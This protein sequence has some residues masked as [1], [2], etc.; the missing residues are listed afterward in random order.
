MYRVRGRNS[1]VGLDW[2]R[3]CRNSL[4]VLRSIRRK[5]AGNGGALDTPE[6][7][8]L[9]DLKTSYLHLALGDTDTAAEDLVS[10]W[11]TGRRLAAGPGSFPVFIVAGLLHDFE[12]PG[13]V[14][15]ACRLR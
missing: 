8:A 11:R 14:K 4:E 13:R 3:Q 9:I 1:S 5:G 2:A 10:A 15:P 7:L 12:S 6:P